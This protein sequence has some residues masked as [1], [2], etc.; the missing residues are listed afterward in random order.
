MILLD[1]VHATE[2]WGD[3]SVPTPQ[4]RVGHDPTWRTV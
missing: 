4:C 1:D 3:K 2:V